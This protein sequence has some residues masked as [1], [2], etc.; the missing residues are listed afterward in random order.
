M[1]FGTVNAGGI[2]QKGEKGASVFNV[3][4]AA[5]IPRNQFAAVIGETL[6]A[7]YTGAPAARVGDVLIVKSMYPGDDPYQFIG[8]IT[9][10]TDD[11]H[12]NDTRYFT[13]RVDGI[14]TGEKGEKG[15]K[16][17]TG[18]TGP[19]GP[20][21]S[22]AN[23]ERFFGLPTAAPPK[24]L[25]ILTNPTGESKRVLVASTKMGVKLTFGSF[26]ESFSNGKVDE[27]TIPA[28]GSAVTWVYS[29]Q[30]AMAHYEE[31]QCHSESISYFGYDEA[32]NWHVYEI[33]TVGV[34][35]VDSEAGAIAG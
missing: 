15:E 33:D 16:G 5:P 19:Q 26:I 20:A 27:I 7:N 32:N 8:T 18:E 28:N 11:D 12:G 4:T 35:Q 29:G 25:L 10:A 3:E 30:F 17:D 13:L 31:D 23:V 2:G 21:G 24:Q 1:A 22:D 14:L 9:A 6:P 34:M